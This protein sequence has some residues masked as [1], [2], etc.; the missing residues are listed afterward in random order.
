CS[1]GPAICGNIVNLDVKIGPDGASRDAINFAVEVGGS[2]KVG[3]D[4]VR[5]QAGVIGIADR[6]VSP[7]RSGGIEVLVYTAKHV[8]IGA[9]ACAAEPGPRCGKGGNRRPGIRRRRVLIRVLDSG[10]VDDTAETINVATH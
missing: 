2:V 8:D 1:H 5:G 4:G 9:V 3:G 7:K 6:V 10:V